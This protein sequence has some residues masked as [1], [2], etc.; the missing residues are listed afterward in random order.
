VKVT[1]D[2]TENSQA[3]LTIEMEPAEVEKS[4]D[5]ACRQLTRQTRVPGFRKGKTPRDVLERYL[6]KER[7]LEEALNQLLPDACDRAIKEQE[8]KPVTQPSIELTKV[9]PV[10]FKVV[11]PLMPTVTLGDYRSIRLGAEKVAVTEDQVNTILEGLRRQYAVME[12]VER[13]ADFKDLVV[14]D[15]D[16]TLDGAPFIKR[17]GLQFQLIQGLGTPAPGFSEQLAGMSKGEEKEFTLSMP[18]NYPRKEMAGKQAFF[19]VKVT[20]IKQEVLPEADDALAR[21][22]SPE[23]DTLAVLK[24]EIESNLRQN[25]EQKA[26]EELEGKLI[27]AVVACSRVEFPPVMVDAEVDRILRERMGQSQMTEQDFQN[28]LKSIKKTE[29]E[30]KEELRPVAAQRIAGYLVLPRVAREEGIE[31]SDGEVD[32]EIEKMLEGAKE[33]NVE[34]LRGAMQNPESR[35]SIRQSMIIRRTIDRLV[36]IAAGP[37]GG[38]TVKEEKKN[39]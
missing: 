28:Y 38:T 20:D 11:V 6:G 3:Y 19:R 9:E 15:I 36:A 8:L 12:P 1:R 39:E 25:A 2:K 35:A 4:K 31:V 5:E 23:F 32:A 7:I 18:A 33:A 29:T 13:A 34:E 37:E 17:Q 26:R 22:I 21:R 14:M 16:S 24:Q 27:E 30:L 10:V